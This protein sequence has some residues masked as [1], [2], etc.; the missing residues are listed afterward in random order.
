[1]NA[2]KTKEGKHVYAL[3]GGWK[4]HDVETDDWENPEF[5]KLR[6]QYPYISEWFK[7]TPLLKGKNYLSVRFP[8]GTNPVL[9]GTF[10]YTIA[11]ELDEDRENEQFYFYIDREVLITFNLDGHTRKIM[12]KP[13]RVSMLHQCL[14]P[15]DGMFVLAR[16]ILHY[17]HAGMDKFEANL[18]EVEAVMRRHNQRNLM[19]RILSS[20]FELLYWSNLF[21]PFQELIAASKEG[22]LDSLENSRFYQQLLH[23]V[24][25]MDKLFRHYERE[26]DTL[27]TIDDAIAG[28]RGNEIMKTLTIMTVIFTPATVVGAIWGMNFENLPITKVSWGFFAAMLFTFALT[29]GM[30]VWMYTKGWTGDLLRVKSK[31]KNI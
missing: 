12:G 13:D 14:R 18:R 8:D 3:A 9:V 1:M 11:S 27:V 30:Y 22:Y 31:N 29:V 16:A 24:E 23:R 7:L 4:W 21:I 19:D 28:F 26:I 17:F 15:I 2:L 20:R 5:G 10:L 6:N 25:R